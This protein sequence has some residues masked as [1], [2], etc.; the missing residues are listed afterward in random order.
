[1]LPGKNAMTLVEVLITVSLI[2]MLSVFL[3]PAVGHAVQQREN[4]LAASHLRLAVNVFELYFS[5]TGAYPEDVSR[6]V[7]PPEMADYFIDLEIVDE[8]GYGWW[9]E[10]NELGGKWDWDKDNNFSYS[11]SIADPSVSQKQLEKFDALVDD[12]DLTTG[13]LRKVDTRYHYILE[14]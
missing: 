1:M 5:E 4:G 12:G 9:T 3:V 13:R 7:V 11:V 2:A 14:E 10:V 6:A 8:S